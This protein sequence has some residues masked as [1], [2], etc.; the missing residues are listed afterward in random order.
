MININEINKNKEISTG[1]AKTK[2]TSSGESFSAYLNRA[3]TAEEDAPVSIAG[4]LSG[5]DVLLTAQMITED[6]E[7]E[8]RKKNL[9]RGKKL[10]EKLEE[11]RDGLLIG[12]LSK[13]RLIEIAR[14]VREQPFP[15]ADSQ[16][17]EILAEIELRVEVEL[18]KLTK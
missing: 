16:I 2:R 7:E 3:S 4:S 18:A 11:I 5:A 15:A 9:Q 1:T 14:Y 8:L 12:S 13:E 10:I 17:Q 6:D